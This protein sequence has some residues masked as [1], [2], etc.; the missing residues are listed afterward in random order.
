MSVSVKPKEATAIINSLIGGVVP[1][2]G[3]QHITVG[4]SDEV[5]TFIKALNDVKD[6]HSMVKFWIGDF[7]SGKSFMLHLLTTV[8]LKQKF[9]VTNADLTPHTRLYSNDGKA[10]ALY[11]ALM[12]NVAVVT[13]PEGGALSLLL[14]KWI[15]QTII[16][17]AHENNIELAKIRELQ[18]I[19]LIND[20]I[21]KTINRITEVGG[22]DFGLAIVK[23]YEGFI[24][25]NEAL[26]RNALR[27]LKGEYSTKTEAKKDLGVSDII[28]DRNYYDMLKNFTKLFVSIG[29]SGFVINLDEC[30]N[31]YKI[32]NTGMRQKN[33]ET[34]MSMY[35]DCF[36]GKIEHLFLNFAGTGDTLEDAARGFYSYEALKSRL[37]VNKF[38]TAQI[39][40]FAQP[41]IRLMP[42]DHNEI[43]VLLKNLKDIFDFNYQVKVDF[44]DQDIKMYMEEMYNKPGANEFLTPREVI[45]DFLNILN[46]LRQNRQADK[47]RLIAE[48]HIVDE[49]SLSLEDDQER[50][51]TEKAKA[52]E[53]QYRSMNFAPQFIDKLIETL[54]DDENCLRVVSCSHK[55]KAGTLIATEKRLVF[56]SKLLDN[57][58][59]FPYSRIDELSYTKGSQN[60]TLR[61][62]LD[63]V[64]KNIDFI[65]NVQIKAFLTI[66]ESQIE[67]LERKTLA[68]ELSY[69]LKLIKKQEV[70]QRL[71]KMIQIANTIQDK[72]PEQSHTFFVRHAD[73]LVK[74]LNQYFVLENSGLDTVETIEAIQKIE[75]ALGLAHVAF[76]QE[77]NNIFKLDMMNVE[78]ESE[79]YM[80]NLRNRGLLES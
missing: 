60:S 8:A 26:K 6:G 78:A 7:G 4:R 25:G 37:Q 58:E 43:F 59:S 17:T 30:I 35:N 50:I 9:I 66:L 3:V 62:T 48:I 16:Q 52:I 61:M 24:A 10:Q 28:D 38:E 77:L 70:K 15:E 69:W 53:K 18:Y 74:M 19:P 47:Q 56:I 20:A 31:L 2:I 46:I 29:Y 63:K 13:K 55:N 71:E 72:D 21:M 12:D 34:L 73:A 80:Q 42:L 14:E 67:I 40:D 57:V 5:E 68:A 76:E 51:R 36:Q 49:R 64:K 1:K 45:R 79:V 65:P 54:L 11:T 22:F 39:R 33:Y 41:V 23:Y 27:W 44:S 32:S 75:E